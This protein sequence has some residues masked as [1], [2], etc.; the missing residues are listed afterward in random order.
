MAKRTLK[1]ELE[2]RIIE[3]ELDELALKTNL[4]RPESAAIVLR[5]HGVSVNDLV[6]TRP[7]TPDEER[8]LG[9][10][11]TLLDDLEPGEALESKK[12]SS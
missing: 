11:R 1:R 10:G 12:E 5:S 8:R 3:K 7:L 9:I 4:P 2:P 6:P